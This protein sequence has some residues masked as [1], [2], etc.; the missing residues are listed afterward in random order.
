METFVHVIEKSKNQKLFNH[1]EEQGFTLS[2]PAYTL[3]SA[4]KPGLSVTLFTSQKC[5]IQGKGAAEFIEFFFEPEILE[6]FSSPQGPSD[7][8]PH[9]GVDES[10]KGDF[11]GPLVIA[12]VFADEAGVNALLSLGVKDSKTLKDKAIHTMAQKIKQVCPFQIVILS[13]LKYNEIYESFKNLNSLLAWGHATI[14]EALTLKTGCKEALI[15]Q[16]ADERVV[17]QALKRKKLELNLTQ[18]TK[19]ESDPVVAAASILARDAFVQEMERLSGIAG[20]L[21]P[22]GASAQVKTA[23]RTL[24]REKGRDVLGNFAKLHFKTLDTL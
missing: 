9:I 13:P 12:G 19:G 5:V 15:D 6:T 4:R 17:I 23:A 2:Q 3:F 14:L 16:F 1:L 7:F 8:I 21:L 22:K 11:F 10:G 18:R 24:I 20:V